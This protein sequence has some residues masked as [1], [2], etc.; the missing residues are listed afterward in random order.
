MNCKEKK[1][2]LFLHFH[3]MIIDC[4]FGLR[5]T[6]DSLHFISRHSFHEVHF[7]HF[8]DFVT[9]AFQCNWLKLFSNK[10][11]NYAKIMKQRYETQNFILSWHHRKIKYACYELLCLISHL[12][13][14]TVYQ[15]LNKNQL[16]EFKS[17]SQ[18]QN[19]ISNLF[20]KELKVMFIFNWWD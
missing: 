12:M 19:S 8:F 9:L 13:I 15:N 14:S 5:S 10:F 20:D 2:F 11:S 3:A 18:L 17:I 1:I 7:L 16:F 6:S 4:H